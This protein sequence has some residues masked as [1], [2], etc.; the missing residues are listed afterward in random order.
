MIYVDFIGL[1]REC[2]RCPGGKDSIRR[3][4]QS[5]FVTP[6]SRVLEIG[7]NTGF[8]SLEIARVARCNV[9]GVDLAAS[10][11]AESRRLLSTDHP[12]VQARVQFEVADAGALPF[13]RESFDLVVAGGAT[14]FVADRRRAL[15]EFHRVLRPWGFLS[16]TTLVYHTDP[17]ADLLASLSAILG[18]RLEPH[19][20]HYWTRM[21]ASDG[22][23]ELYHAE[24][25]GFRLPSANDRAAYVE[26][27]LQKPHIAGWSKDAKDAIRRRWSETLDSFAENHRYLD[28]FLGIFRKR[29]LAEEPELFLR[30]TERGA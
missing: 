26:Y 12:S 15:S 23:F 3:I 22:Q 18:F 20:R 13:S 30:D 5:A 28:Y 9:V 27:F 11:V 25:H 6:D 14:G 29:Y 7:S 2:N 1:I 16:V 19:D 17:P 10:A 24:T 4:L 8:T 21:I